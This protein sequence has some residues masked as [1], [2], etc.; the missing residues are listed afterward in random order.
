MRKTKRNMKKIFFNFITTL[1][2]ALSFAILVELI[3]A[4][5]S[6]LLLLI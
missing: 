3:K 2:K 4:I 5:I 1:V 6:G